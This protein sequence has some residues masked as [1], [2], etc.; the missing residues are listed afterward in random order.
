MRR[1]D[2]GRFASAGRTYRRGEIV[3]VCRI[4]PLREDPGPVLAPCA[5]VTGGE[6]K[7][8]SMWSGT[9]AAKGIPLGYGALYVRPGKRPDGG[10]AANVKGSIAKWEYGGHV[11]IVRALCNIFICQELVLYDVEGPENIPTWT[12]TAPPKP[13][14][15]KNFG[16]VNI[17]FGPA[18]SGLVQWGHSMLHG[19]GVFAIEAREKQQVLD[20]CPALVLDS[21]SARAA[22]DYTIH[23]SACGSLEAAATVLALGLGAL[24]NDPRDGTGTADYFYDRSL[25]L[26]AFISKQ[27]IAKGEEVL[28]DYGPEYW[29]TRMRNRT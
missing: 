8:E 21:Q 26:V 5:V 13:P 18:T 4:M 3:E 19:A 1:P 12:E 2:G 17:A 29:N 23:V 28:I 25:E 22:R 24:C 10:P 9:G 16:S 15:T 14:D 27:H 7:S 11:L 6:S 20:L